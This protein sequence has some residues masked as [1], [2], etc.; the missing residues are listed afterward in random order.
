MNLDL[1]I[2][3]LSRDEGRVAHAYQDHLGFWTIGVGHLI[4][5]RR[6]GGLPDPFIDRLL[7]YDIAEK[8][9]QLD[10]ALP[11]W[12][13]LSDA[14]QRALLNMCFQLG[15]NGLLKFKN[16][17]GFIKSGEWQEAHDALLQSKLAEQTPARAKRVAEMIL[18]G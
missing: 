9:A 1:L 11:W 7:E 14:R 13:D 5:K 18:K 6:N 17:L 15:I 2:A 3:E 8:A 16:T 12:R 4:D 10:T